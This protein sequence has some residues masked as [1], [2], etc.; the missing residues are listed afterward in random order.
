MKPEIASKSKVRQT[1]CLAMCLRGSSGRVII[2]A[3]PSHFRIR[4]E[5]SKLAAQVDAA[6]PLAQAI[7]DDVRA[8]TAA[9]VGVSREPYGPG[10]QAAV[11]RVVEAARE[12]DLEVATDPFG[13]VYLT[14]QG[15][16]RGRP[17]W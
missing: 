8:K 1:M 17:R 16:D 5:S 15:A 10:E 12:L 6:V 13:N 14:L 2:A 7:F 11:D 3:H 4:M 9:G